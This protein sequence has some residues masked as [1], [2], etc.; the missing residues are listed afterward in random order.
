MP[1]SWPSHDA[2]AVPKQDGPFSSATFTPGLT[3][4][5]QSNQIHAA[6]QNKT[7]TD[8]SG[9]LSDLRFCHLS[10]IQAKTLDKKST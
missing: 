6:S 8:K 4:A 1:Q 10:A 7:L 3:I 2:I 5:L 9:S